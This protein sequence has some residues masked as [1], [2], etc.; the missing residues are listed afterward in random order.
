MNI[1]EEA[2]EAAARAL[3]NERLGRVGLSVNEV[4][5]Y[6][7]KIR[8]FATTPEQA[9]AA[10]QKAQ[11]IAETTPTLTR[12]ALQTVYKDLIANT[13]RIETP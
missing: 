8:R 4:R 13:L 1:P 2:I 12:D 6:V 3:N 10:I 11:T 9:E 7:E 5:E